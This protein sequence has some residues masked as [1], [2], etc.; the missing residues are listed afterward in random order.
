[1]LVIKAAASRKQR[2]A[3][4]RSS[5]KVATARNEFWCLCSGPESGNIIACDIPGCPIEWFHFECVGL[6]DAP[7]KKRR[8]LECAV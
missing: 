3:R 2:T 8:C 7:N 4:Q 5:D 1:M 6:V